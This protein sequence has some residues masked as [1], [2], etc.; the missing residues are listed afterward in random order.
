[1]EYEALWGGHPDVEL[2]AAW[3]SGMAVLDANMGRRP[4]RRLSSSP[5][6]S[7]G[8]SSTRHVP[9]LLGPCGCGAEAACDVKARC[10]E[11]S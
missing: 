1:L 6:S 11:K 8:E 7:S 5:R 10:G 9:S 2:E 4:A 3:L